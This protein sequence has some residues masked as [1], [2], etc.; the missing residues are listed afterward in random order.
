MMYLA[1]AMI[2]S[3]MPRTEEASMAKVTFPG[4]ASDLISPILST[5]CC[6][7]CSAI[8]FLRLLTF[9]NFF[10]V[11]WYIFRSFNAQSALAIINTQYRDDDIALFADD[12]GA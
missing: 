9:K 10:T 12:D 5:T 11:H 7:S 2:L 8:G 6:S 3:Q 1:S 4:K